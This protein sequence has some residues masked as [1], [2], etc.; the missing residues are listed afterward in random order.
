MNKIINLKSS[1]K[2]LQFGPSKCKT[3]FV[4]KQ[5]EMFLDNDLY[6]DKWKEEFEDNIETNEE[7][8]I[9]TYV[10]QTKI[11]KTNSQK[12]LSF[13]ISGTRDN[14]ANIEAVR[15][16]LIGVVQKIMNKLE[17]LSLMKYFF[18]CAMIF[19]NAFL[20]PSILYACKTY[21]NLT[22]TRQ[23]ERLKDRSY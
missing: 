8:L 3:I 22:E 1:E 17:S 5:H 10:S 9:E 20:R 16:K 19:M 15:K 7:E 23:I 14:M 11:G 2:G 12:Y 13:V 4:G 21:Y 6:V 18:E